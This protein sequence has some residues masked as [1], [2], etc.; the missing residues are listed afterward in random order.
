MGMLMATCARQVALRLPKAPACD[1]VVLQLEVRAFTSCVFV[2]G[3][4]VSPAAAST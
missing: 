4:H 1:E 2:M 3:A